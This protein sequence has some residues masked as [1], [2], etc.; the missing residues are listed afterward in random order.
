[1]VNFLGRQGSGAPSDA[2]T[3]QIMRE[4]AEAFIEVNA[5]QGD[6]FGWENKEASRLDAVCDRFLGTNPSAG[7]RH[8]MV[9]A[10]GA[11]LGE[12]MVRHGQGRWLYGTG[13]RKAVVRLANGLVLYPHDQVAKR[14]ESGPQH[15]LGFYFHYAM[16][17]HTVEDALAG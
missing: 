10:M 15:D 16:A 12:L 6:R 2:E 9:M 3:G 17:G 11:Y 8:S 4:L 1:M 13:D 7:L 14:L 5:E